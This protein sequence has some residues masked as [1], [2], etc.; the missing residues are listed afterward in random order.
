MTPKKLFYVLMGL[1]LVAGAGGGA[2][3]YFGMQRLQTST[4]QIQAKLGEQKTNEET[5]TSLRAAKT[6]YQREI[7]PILPTIAAVL[8]PTKNQSE[9]LIQLQT[10]AKSSGLSISS[11]SF[12]AAGTLPSQTS[13]TIKSGDALALPITF[14]VRGR[15]DQ[16]QTF[17]TSL[18]TLQ[19]LTTVTN[20]VISHPDASN[21]DLLNYAL[22][23]NTFIKP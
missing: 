21:P 14:Q 18:E 10:L 6:K 2:G 1:I 20:L 22:T 19:R 9:I 16:L 17:L 4:A 8:P 13:Q 12:P 5:L 15:Y 23:V 7:V 3:Y 11:A